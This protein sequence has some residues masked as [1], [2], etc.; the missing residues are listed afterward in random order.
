MINGGTVRVRSCR[1]R[2]RYVPTVQ[3]P[4]REPPLL[5]R[6]GGELNAPLRQTIPIV[7]HSFSPAPPT[8]AQR[9]GPGNTAASLTPT[10]RHK[11]GAVRTGLPDP[12]VQAHAAKLF[13]GMTS[14]SKTP[15]T[16]EEVSVEDFNFGQE[17]EAGDLDLAEAKYRPKELLEEV[18]V[19]HMLSRLSKSTIWWN[20]S[21]AWCR[22]ELQ[23]RVEL[24]VSEALWPGAPG[25]VWHL[26]GIASPT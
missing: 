10:R 7:P 15:P 13:V 20:R 24:Q 14:A 17:E 6:R 21:G 26:D 2:V 3:P 4:T 19:A 12:N 22:L 5:M 16:R 23:R 9:N 11:H 18:T 1:T 8:L 25:E